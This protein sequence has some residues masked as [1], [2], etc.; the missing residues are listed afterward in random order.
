MLKNKNKINKKGRKEGRK[1]GKKEGKINLE[2]MSIPR[3]LWDC[4]RQPSFWLS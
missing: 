2:L 1:E 3:R 4:E